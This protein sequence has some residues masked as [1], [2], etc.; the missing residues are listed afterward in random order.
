MKKALEF[1]LRGEYIIPMKSVFRRLF[2]LMALVAML[3]TVCFAVIIKDR[4]NAYSN[5]SDIVVQ[6]STADESSVL[7]FEVLRRAGISGDFLS[8]ASLDKKGDNSS[9]EY[10]DRSVF[11]GEAGIYQYKVRVVNGQVPSPETDIVTV[12]HVSSTA[13]RTW[14]SIKAMFR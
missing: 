4:P 1:H 2:P 6:W 10:V 8:I 3:A 11:K 5:G 9:Y 14:G 13:R 7:H 12:S